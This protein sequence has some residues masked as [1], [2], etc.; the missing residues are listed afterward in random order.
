MGGIE[1]ADMIDGC[2]LSSTLMLFSR[3]SYGKVILFEW[4]PDEKKYIIL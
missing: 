1:C 3:R 4:K 2:A